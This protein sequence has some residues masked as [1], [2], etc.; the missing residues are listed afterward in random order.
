[1]AAQATPQYEFTYILDGVLAE[2]Q[3][4]DLVGRISKFISKNGGEVVET[5]EW[6]MRQLA[7]PIRNRNNGYYVNLYFTSSPDLPAKIERTLRIEESVLRFLI[8]KLD[9]KMKRHYVKQKSQREAVPTP[10]EAETPV[11]APA[12]AA[13]DVSVEAPVEA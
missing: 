9:A 2:D 7:Y 13:L 12:K 5:D 3:I 8:L 1:M 4:K 11:E 6:G 10:K